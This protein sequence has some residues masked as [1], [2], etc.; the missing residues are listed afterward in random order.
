MTLE[1]V[2]EEDPPP[3]FL[4]PP[5]ALE[6]FTFAFEAPSLADLRAEFCVE[7]G[8]DNSLLVFSVPPGAICYWFVGLDLC[9]H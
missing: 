8:F 6:A 2:A 1:A 3:E 4:A 9:K 7:Q 5:T